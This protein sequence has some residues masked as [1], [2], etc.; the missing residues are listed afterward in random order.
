MNLQV[1]RYTPVFDTSDYSDFSDYSKKLVRA[2]AAVYVAD[3]YRSFDSRCLLC[4]HKAV[5]PE[6]EEFYLDTTF[7]LLSNLCV[8][9]D[10][11]EAAATWADLQL[12]LNGIRPG[13][14]VTTSVVDETFRVRF[15]L[16]PTCLSLGG[17]ALTP[18]EL[19]MSGLDIS[20]KRYCLLK[21]RFRYLKLQKAGY[22]L[23]RKL[24]F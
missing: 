8:V 21:L 11:T 2:Y 19:Q 23:K 7:H 17:A 13:H 15:I 4:Q 20:I 3:F 18:G 14:V 22:I 1:S 9:H 16:N 12:R 10:C 5:S 6:A 24:R